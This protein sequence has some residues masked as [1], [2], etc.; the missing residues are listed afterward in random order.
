M[1]A[2]SGIESTHRL[3]LVDQ[4]HRTYRAGEYDNWRVW[5]GEVAIE[6]DGL[7][8]DATLARAYSR[9]GRAPVARVRCELFFADVEAASFRSGD[10]AV[11]LWTDAMYQAG[12]HVTMQLATGPQGEPALCGANLVFES[13]P[14]ALARTGAFSYAVEVAA[15]LD[16]GVSWVPIRDIAPNPDGVIVVSPGWVAEAPTVTEVC[17]RKVDARLSQGHFRSG[18]IENLTARLDQLPTDV[19]YLLP[20]FLPGFTDLHTGKDVRKGTLGSVYAVA[21]FYQIDPQLVTP[22]QQVD[23]AGLLAAGLLHQED[24]TDVWAR[25]ER[26]VSSESGQEAPPT[27]AELISAGGADAAQ[28][29]GENRIVQLVGRAELRQLCRRAHELG[30]RVIFDLVLMQTSRDSTLITEHPEWYALDKQGQPKIHQIAWLVYS[31]VALFDLNDNKPLQ[32]YLLEVAPYWMA[33][34]QLDGVRL[35][36]SQTVDR[37]FLIGLKNR[38]QQQDPEALVLG[39]TLCPLKDAV[40]IPVDMVYALM[41]DFHRDAV[42]A[43]PLIDFLEEV[44]GTFAAGTV[45][46]AYFENHDSLR[47]TQIWMERNGNALND[48]PGLTRTWRRPLAT[49]EGDPAR[50]MA[51]LKNL[52]A[53]MINATAGMWPTAVTR[54]EPPTRPVR[55]GG[56]QLAWAIEW[57]SDWGETARTDFENDSLLHPDG[58]QAGPGQQLAGIYQQLPGLLSDW[59]ESRRGGIYYHRNSGPGGDAEDRVLAYTRHTDE[60]A[61]L[62]VHNLDIHRTR[63]V[64]VPLDWL[65]WTP[66]EPHMVFDSYAALG[67]TAMAADPDS[68]QQGVRLGVAPLQTCLFRMTADAT[69]SRKG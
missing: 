53:T 61:L 48:D 20:F 25:I 22:P 35:D 50:W 2:A 7:W 44:H 29:W 16:G 63:W 38:I 60:N 43:E 28:R 30:K 24:V 46:M 33:C 1:T 65:P 32:D 66:G 6:I 9:P 55:S 26:Q 56:T 18:R 8:F 17:L 12:D 64:T 14:F 41:V 34:C 42:Q 45:A 10:V 67:L 13:E 59:S 15:S 54:T 62:A 37:P 31:D 52:Q 51:L 58:R 57:G 36:A 11:R 69:N 40:D 68:T 19:V 21:D 23:L 49:T 27:V 4:L 39:E 5:A 3:T 47:A